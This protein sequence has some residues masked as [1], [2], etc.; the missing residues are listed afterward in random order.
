VFTGQTRQD[1]PAALE[2]MSLG[3]ENKALVVTGT[4]DSFVDQIDGP[5]LGR[6]LQAGRLGEDTG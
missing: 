5:S 1:F 2:E 4:G 3:R 6:D